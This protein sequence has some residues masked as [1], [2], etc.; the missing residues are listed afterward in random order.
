MDLR[1]VFLALIV[2]AS[3]A[4]NV[5]TPVTPTPG[6]TPFPIDTPTPHPTCPACNTPTPEPWPT[7]TPAAGPQLD[8]RFEAMG[9]T[10]NIR[11]A[12]RYKLI[13][14]WAWRFGDIATAPAWAQKWMGAPQ[15]GA[16]HNVFGVV[17][18]T[19]V[20]VDF[21]L[22]W[23]DGDTVRA[24]AG[25]IDVPIYAKYYPPNAGPYTWRV[26]GGDELKGLGLWQ[27]E[28]W[29]FAGVWIDTEPLPLVIG[30][31]ATAGELEP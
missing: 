14:A 8:E 9:V 23:P 18:G 16:D 28:H 22:Y 27:G 1:T 11:P 13:A 19:A 6:M 30:R 21:R 31:E 10:V 3:S 17:V 29:S 7:A 12:A 2:A 26:D 20:P 24:A 15:M 4:C 25:W 5:V